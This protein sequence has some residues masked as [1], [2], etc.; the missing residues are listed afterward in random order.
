MLC[1]DT[2]WIVWLESQSCTNKHGHFVVI[3]VQTD[4]TLCGNVCG[5][6]GYLVIST[7]NAG[8]RENLGTKSALSFHSKSVNPAK[9]DRFEILMQ[10]IPHDT[11][12]KDRN[13]S[14]GTRE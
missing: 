1:D 8:L 12:D 13:I 2:S 9:V 6:Q 4:N 5:L 3:Q 11:R 10:N 7:H 14:L